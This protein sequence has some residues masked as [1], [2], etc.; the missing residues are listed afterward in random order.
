MPL[1]SLSRQV[2]PSEDGYPLEVWESV[3]PPGCYV[4]LV[5]H[6]PDDETKAW[7]TRL[8]DRGTAAKR[9]SHPNITQILDVGN[10]R[11]KTYVASELLIGKPN[12]AD[13]AVLVLR[14]GIGVDRAVRI[15]W[16]VA[17]AL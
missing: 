6:R 2:R 1:P 8:L 17:L 10:D 16:Q 13:V 14:G 7:T 4:K 9:V 15:T 12:E 11:G 3:S 5:E